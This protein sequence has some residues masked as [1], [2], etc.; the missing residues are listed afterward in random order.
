VSDSRGEP[1]Q[2][3]FAKLATQDRYKLLSF[4][5]VP[6]PIAWVSTLDP[7]GRCNL[8]PFSFFNIVAT[9]PP[10]LAMGITAR[11]RG[12]DTARNIRSS[13]EFVVQL[14]PHALIHQMNVSAIEFP[15]EI[16]EIATA[17][18][19]TLASSRVR[20][21]RLADS[22]VAYECRTWQM[23]DLPSGQSV[24]IGEVLVGHIA[25]RAVIDATRCH[26]DT[27]ALDLVGRMD[28][29]YIRSGEVFDL[30]RITL[31]Q[32][33]ADPALVGGQGQ[34]AAPAAPMPAPSLDPSLAASANAT[35]TSTE[36]T[37]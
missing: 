27:G 35:A 24:I 16:D 25:E 3:D 4:T 13:G 22:P 1:V 2:F 5:V 12:K 21:P 9:D 19:A 11:P 29:R 34:G 14:V 32:W 18:L 17:G 23:L 8:A 33:R 20:P 37:R 15:P 10:L 7:E 6:R 26:I 28:N 31:D 30:P 36:P